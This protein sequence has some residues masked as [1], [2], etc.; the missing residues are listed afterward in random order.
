M[1]TRYARRTAAA[2]LHN[3]DSAT[4]WICVTNLDCEESCLLAFYRSASRRTCHHCTC[5]LLTGGGNT[6]LRRRR[7]RRS[8][9]A[10]ARDRIKTSTSEPCAMQSDDDV[11]EVSAEEAYMYMFTPQMAWGPVWHIEDMLE[12][13]ETDQPSTLA[14]KFRDRLHGAL[15]A[16][17]SGQNARCQWCTGGGRTLSPDRHLCFRGVLPLRGNSV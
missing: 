4:S 3:I 6:C 17:S 10:R 5:S 1:V 2:A 9:P 8:A 7:R 13:M 12:Q 14:G 16:C 11:V 15:L